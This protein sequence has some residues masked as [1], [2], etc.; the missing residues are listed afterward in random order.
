MDADIVV[1]KNYDS[2]M[3]YPAFGG[4]MLGCKAFH[5]SMLNGGLFIIQ[6]NKSLFEDIQALA[7]QPE[8]PWTYSEQELLT[9][10][11]TNL[12]PERMHALPPTEMLPVQGL[13]Y[14]P[15]GEWEFGDV[16]ASKV[17]PKVTHFLCMNKPWSVGFHSKYVSRCR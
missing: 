9:Y 10:Y 2:L 3:D 13:E 8:F 6:P 17:G 14:Y 12:H 11:Y 5:F 4:A 15:K 1:R 7:S 16:Y